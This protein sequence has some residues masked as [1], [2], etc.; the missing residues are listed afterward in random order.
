MDAA[1]LKRPHR[2]RGT[3]RA[4][5]FPRRH[6]R[7]LIEALGEAQVEAERQ[8]FRVVM[9]AASLKPCGLPP[10]GKQGGRFR[11]VMDAASLKQHGAQHAGHN[12]AWFPR[13]HG[14]GLIEATG[15]T[16]PRTSPPRCFRVVM[17]AAS[18]K[19]A[20]AGTSPWRVPPGLPRRH[21][22][23]LIEARVRSSSSWRVPHVSASSW[24]RPH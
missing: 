11:V 20:G 16:P 19:P 4:P 14:R 17:D 5:G 15:A 9:D 13:R 24:T 7:G 12:D 3:G 6:G 21:G 18:L 2:V 10:G 1:S 8:G 23:G 22:R